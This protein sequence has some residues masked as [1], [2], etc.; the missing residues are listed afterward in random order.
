[1]AYY[2]Y[3]YSYAGFVL[4]FASLTCYLDNN[5]LALSDTGSIIPN[6]KTSS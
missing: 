3:L 6:R 4:F 5:R 1:M 2:C